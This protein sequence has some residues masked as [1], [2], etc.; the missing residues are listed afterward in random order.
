MRALLS[1]HILGI[2]RDSSLFFVPQ[3]G[4]KLQYKT[5]T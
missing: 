5:P 1:E 3:Y 2:Y 4:N